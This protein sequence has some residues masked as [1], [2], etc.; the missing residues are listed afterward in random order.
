MK[1]N[2]HLFHGKDD[3]LLTKYDGIFDSQLFDNESFI[4]D[5]PMNV[6]LY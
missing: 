6:E 5:T 2:S 4:I 1:L 3:L